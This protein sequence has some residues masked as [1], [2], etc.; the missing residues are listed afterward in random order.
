MLHKY[1]FYTKRE[2][3][4]AKSYWRDYHNIHV[5]WYTTGPRSQSITKI[6]IDQKKFNKDRLRKLS[7]YDQWK[8]VRTVKNLRETMGHYTS[9]RVQLDSRTTHVCNETV[10]NYMNWN[11]YYL[12]SRKRSILTATDLKRHSKYCRKVTWWGVEATSGENKY[13]YILMEKDS[14]T[15]SISMHPK[16]AYIHC[17]LSQYTLFSVKKISLINSFVQCGVCC[18]STQYI[19]ILY[20]C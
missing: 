3:F 11:G 17:V 19:Y 7:A 13:Q 1:K 15:K 8:V 18:D 9:M 10:R 12:H 6:L 2:R 16:Q 14:S 20:I 4:M 5:H